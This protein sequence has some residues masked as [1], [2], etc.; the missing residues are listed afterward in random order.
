MILA[1]DLLLLLLNDMSGKALTDKT[2]LDLALAGAVLL[3]LTTLGRV[4]VAADGEQVKAGRLVVRDVST[5]GD[6]VLDEGLRRIEASRPKKPEG[7]L[8]AL[9]KGLRERLLERLVERGIVRAEEGRVLGIFPTHSWPAVTSDHERQVRAALMDVLVA[10]RTPAPREA[11]LV[12]LL[13]AIDQ[14]PKVLGEVN[15][16]ARDLRRR[17]KEISEGGFADVAVR[18]AVQAVNSAM[19]AAVAGAIVAGG[20][21]SG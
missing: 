6:D 12:S 17:A 14:V 1:E 9:V 7:V 13:Q 18:K 20:A 19:T 3:D 5:T 2:R 21:A 8:P 4:D 10:G 11:A 15:V 16:P